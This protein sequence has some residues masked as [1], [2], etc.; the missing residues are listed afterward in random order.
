MAAEKPLILNESMSRL[1]DTTSMSSLL[2]RRGLIEVE[3]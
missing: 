2:V 1:L 3:I